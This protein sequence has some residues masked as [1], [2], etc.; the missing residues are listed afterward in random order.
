MRKMKTARD[1]GMAEKSGR[2]RFMGVALSEMEAVRL[3]FCS[4]K[5]SKNAP[6]KDA[7]AL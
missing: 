4:L 1:I 6:M 3:A 5:H 2:A 7:G